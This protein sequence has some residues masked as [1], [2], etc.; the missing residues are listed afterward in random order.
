MC[1]WM[2]KKLGESP[3]PSSIAYIWTI[4]GCKGSTMGSESRNSLSNFKEVQTCSG[5]SKQKDGYILLLVFGSSVSSNFDCSEL[6]V[7]KKKKA[8]KKGKVIRK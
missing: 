3:T 6:S 8:E 5:I 1:V 4:H 7:K 2:N